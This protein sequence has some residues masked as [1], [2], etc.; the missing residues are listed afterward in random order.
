M[1]KKYSNQQKGMIKIVLAILAFLLGIKVTC[2]GYL[3]IGNLIMFS[4]ILLGIDGCFTY[5][6]GI[7][8]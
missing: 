3:I 4:S 5:L 6:K 8:K 7:I 1:R 2:I